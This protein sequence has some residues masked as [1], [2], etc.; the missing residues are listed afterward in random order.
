VTPTTKEAVG[1]HDQ[2]C[3]LDD[4]V[5]DGRMSRAHLE[6]AMEIALALFALGSAHA[7]S[8]GL[9]LVDTKYELGLIDNEVCVIDEVHTADSSRFWLAETYSERLAHAEAPQMLDKEN[10][11]RWLLAQ[12]FSGTGT[13]PALTDEVRTDL[14][15]HYWDLTERVLGQTVTPTPTLPDALERAV[16]RFMAM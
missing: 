5:R 14:A 3:S 11:R 6:R 7:Q 15:A 13:P 4:L 12:G 8:H 2:P 9:I 10:L 16:L 1:V